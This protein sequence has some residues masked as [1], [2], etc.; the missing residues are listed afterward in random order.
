MSSPGVFWGSQG[1]LQFDVGGR[2]K[3]LNRR[4]SEGEEGDENKG[5][6][7]VKEKEKQYKIYVSQETIGSD[8]PNSNHISHGVQTLTLSRFLH[9][10]R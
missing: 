4:R 7:S 9:R 6:V 5:E 3:K 10:C 1:V 2:G 8:N